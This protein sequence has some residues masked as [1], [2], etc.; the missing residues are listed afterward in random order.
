MEHISYAWHPGKQLTC[1]QYDFNSGYKYSYFLIFLIDCSNPSWIIIGRKIQYHPLGTH[2]QI[3]QEPR[4]FPSSK[5]RILW[6]VWAIIS[7]CSLSLHTVALWNSG[8]AQSCGF[9]GLAT[10]TAQAVVG[11][12]LPK[13]SYPSLN[14]PHKLND[15]SPKSS[16]MP[17]CWVLWLPVSYTVCGGILQ[18]HSG[19]LWPGE[20]TF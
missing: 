6:K 7:S 12:M 16:S 20:A 2:S 10:F 1:S 5:E 9:W 14:H 4:G 13:Q 8:P 18:T 17:G 3:V 15:L 19:S 11:P